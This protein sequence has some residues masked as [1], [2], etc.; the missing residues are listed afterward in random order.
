MLG[1]GL[2]SIFSIFML[3]L[4]GM[5]LT[6]DFGHSH[7]WEY[8]LTVTIG[9]LAACIFFGPPAGGIN[10]ANK[11]VREDG[12]LKYAPLAVPPKGEKSTLEF[13]AVFPSPP[14]PAFRRAFGAYLVLVGSCFTEAFMWVLA[15]GGPIGVLPIVAR[16]YG[17][18]A[19][20]AVYILN[21]IPGPLS[22]ARNSR[23]RQNSFA[24][25]GMVLGIVAVA[26]SCVWWLALPCAIVG[27][28]LSILGRKK[29]RVIGVGSGRATAGLVLCIVA[30]AL[31]VVAAIVW[32]TLLVP[33]RS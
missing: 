33:H 16:N 1:A 13:W 6:G 11:K 3:I 29:A 18:I 5:A 32:G 17:G 20:K 30:L 23:E 12:R 21:G 9:A 31:D 19:G 10:K 26:L 27:L 8:P 7:W 25:A 15:I 24:T 22:P 2:F 14:A 4:A 28:V